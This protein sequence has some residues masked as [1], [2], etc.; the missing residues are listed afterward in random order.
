MK[1]R[2][3]LLGAGFVVVLVIGAALYYVLT[4]L[5]AIVERAIE[6][7]GSEI[8]GTAVRYG[9][10]ITGTA[11]RVDSVEIALTSG[12]GTVRGLRIAN[13][14][15]FSS[16]DTFRLGEIT[17][18]IDIGT[19]RESPIVIDEITIAEPAVRFEVNETGATNI[20]AIRKNAES[21]Q[22]AGAA[23]A[24]KSEKPAADAQAGEPLRLRIRKFSLEDG[25][26]DADT[27]ALGGKESEAKFPPMN[28]SDIGGRQGATPDEIGTIMVKALTKQVAGAV[29]RQQ[30]SSYLEGKLEGKLEGQLKEEREELGEKIDEKL[31]GDAGE[32]AKGLLRSLKK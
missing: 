8:T 14:K 9:S 16:N 26:I 18:Q 11:V 7:Y 27:T 21:H 13:P 3:L 4:S 32:A 10:E 12:R 25:A 2:N 1:L 5:D 19:L 31:G 30:I 23:P 6:R 17:L 24:P 20:D 29:A 28:L 15:G 22:P